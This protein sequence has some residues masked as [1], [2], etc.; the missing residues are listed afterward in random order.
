MV[1]SR[2]AEVF[3][4][5]LYLLDSVIYVDPTST[6]PLEIGTHDFPYKAVLYALK[7]VLN[8]F[9]GATSPISILMKE[10]TN[11]YFS[12]KVVT[13]NLNSLTLS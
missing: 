1:H 9:N 11:N 13:A 7:E 5:I 6:K 2:I 12:E 8:E 3:S 10:G 4:L